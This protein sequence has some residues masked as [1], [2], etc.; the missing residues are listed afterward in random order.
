MIGKSDR[1]GI[2]R[3][4]KPC[5]DGLPNLSNNTKIFGESVRT[6]DA[7]VRRKSTQVRPQQRKLAWLI[8]DTASARSSEGGEY[9]H[10]FSEWSADPEKPESYNFVRPTR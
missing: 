4:T 8:P 10:H 7:M 5:D 6:H 2:E 9:Q 3:S 1:L